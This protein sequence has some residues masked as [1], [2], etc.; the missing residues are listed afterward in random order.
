[1]PRLCDF[2]TCFWCKALFFL[3]GW[4]HNQILKVDLERHFCM[5]TT[6][7][8]GDRKAIIRPCSSKV[9]D[10]EEL[11]RPQ[12]ILGLQLTPMLSAAVKGKMK[13]A[14][15][16][17]SRVRTHM[18]LAEDPSSQLTDLC[19]FGSSLP[20]SIATFLIYR[21]PSSGE[22]TIKGLCSLSTLTCFCVIL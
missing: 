2:W 1:M 22:I 10:L 15:V 7:Q 20:M 8:R 6:G 9:C 18:A 3:F 17:A 13:R 5:V 14:G 12:R 11:R 19:V 21:I 16:M 4:P